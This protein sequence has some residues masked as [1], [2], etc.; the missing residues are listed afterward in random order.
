MKVRKGPSADINWLLWR[1]KNSAQFILVV[2]FKKNKI[3]VREVS[4]L[5]PVSSFAACVPTKLECNMGDY[6]LFAHM[7]VCIISTRVLARVQSSFCSRS[8]LSITIPNFSSHSHNSASFSGNAKAR[9]GKYRKAPKANYHQTSPPKWRL[10][11]DGW[12]PTPLIG[13][14]GGANIDW[15]VVV[16]EW[17]MICSQSSLGPINEAPF[18]GMECQILLISLPLIHSFNILFREDQA[19]L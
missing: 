9:L 10:T 18:H 7:R 19:K 14:A 5:Q 16:M 15:W 8:Q 13:R 12:S 11:I 6:L 3:K 17:L 1:R 2:W 4:R